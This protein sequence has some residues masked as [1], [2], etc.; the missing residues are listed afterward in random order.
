MIRKLGFLVLLAGVLAIPT[1]AH[2]AAPE[3]KDK[4]GDAGAMIHD[5]EAHGLA[6]V[7]RGYMQDGKTSFVFF[8]SP[9]GEAWLEAVMG[10]GRMCL[11]AGGLHWGSIA[12]P[13]TD[14]APDS[15]S[16]DS[17]KGDGS[18]SIPPPPSQQND[19]DGDWRNPKNWT[20]F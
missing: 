5:I 11:I 16:P 15:S 20:T 10:Q 19:G 17:D 9:K 13:P 4:C 1:Y 6:P 3:D 7:A 14:E 8:A 12:V 2:T 18:M